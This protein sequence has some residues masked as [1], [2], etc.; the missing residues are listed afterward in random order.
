[1]AD[2]V[3]FEGHLSRSPDLFKKDKRNH[4]HQVTRL[5]LKSQIE[6]LTATFSRA[7][8]CI[9]LC[10]L[11]QIYGLITDTVCLFYFLS[12]LTVSRCLS[13][14]LLSNWKFKGQR[15]RVIITLQVT[16]LQLA[17]SQTY[18][19]LIGANNSKMCEL[20]RASK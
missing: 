10:D 5:Q 11:R 13:S 4:F 16:G 6:M 8:V 3:S 18:L 19:C 2:N 20:G 17:L 1:M 15:R 7:G 9:S 12:I 14:E